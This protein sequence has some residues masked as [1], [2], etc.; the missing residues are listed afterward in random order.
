[1]RRT[2]IG[3]VAICALL[4]PAAPAFAD[5][6]PILTSG[7]QHP[8]VKRVQKALGVS[9]Q[10]GFFGPITLEAVRTY[11]R[12]HGIPTTGVVGPMTWASLTKDLKAMRNKAKH[13]KKHAKS[14]KRSKQSKRS[15]RSKTNSITAMTLQVGDRGA[16]VLFLQKELGVQPQSGYFGPI[17]E[18]FVKALQ[19]AAKLPVTG[20]VDAKTWRKV[21]KVSFATPAAPAA[22]PATTLPT[23]SNATAAQV[24]KVAASQA[25]VPYVATGYSP[26]QGFNCSSYTQ[27]VY[28]Q[29]G[30]DLGGAYTVWQYDKSRH[31]SAAEA[32]PGDLVFFYNYA[33]NFIGHV[34]IYAGNGMMWHAPRPGR[35]VSLER[36]Y[37]DKVY[38]GRVLNQ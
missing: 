29:V 32:K 38:Y 31:I 5:N 28:K 33:N 1:M 23:P 27:W 16:A 7:M 2:A 22:P 26:E 36:V 20:I 6:Q 17:T 3:G 15:K 9:P 4:T 12:T 35:V 11:Q 14:A 34:G 37:T 30:I 21:G 25:G 8:A 13:A 24:L 19:T 18:S 10:T